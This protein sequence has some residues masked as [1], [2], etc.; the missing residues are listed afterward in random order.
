[1]Q[2]TSELWPSPEGPHPEVGPP[3]SLPG[4]CRAGPLACSGASSAGASR[5]SWARCLGSTLPQGSGEAGRRVRALPSPVG[6]LTPIREREG[7]G[8][9][10]FCFSGNL[11]E[12][13]FGD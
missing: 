6:S 12:R 9:A 3:M 4:P 5:S 11:E 10:A 1:M 7:V 13:V 2:Q 8:G